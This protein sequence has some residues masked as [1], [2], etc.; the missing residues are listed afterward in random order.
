MGT[1]YKIVSIRWEGYRKQGDNLIVVTGHTPDSSSN[2]DYS[3]V[4]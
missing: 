1:A 3:D 2:S 4:L